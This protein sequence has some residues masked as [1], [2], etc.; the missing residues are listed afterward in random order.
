[1]LVPIVSYDTVAILKRDRQAFRRQC[2]RVRGM[3]AWSVHGSVEYH[4]DQRYERMI[5][6]AKEALKIG[7]KTP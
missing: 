5:N 1:M 7:R 2:G 6:E 3:P 4:L